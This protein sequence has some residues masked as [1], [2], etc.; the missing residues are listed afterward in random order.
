[1]NALSLVVR[2]IAYGWAVQL[3]NGQELVRF[4]GP[5]ARRRAL[6]YVTRITHN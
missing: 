4:H 5:G 3:S 1:M 6:R 2:P